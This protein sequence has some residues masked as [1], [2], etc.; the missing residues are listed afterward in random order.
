MIDLI[1]ATAIRYENAMLNSNNSK[2]IVEKNSSLA[3][4][5][6]NIETSVVHFFKR[7]SVHSFFGFALVFTEVQVYSA[8]VP[9]KKTATRDRL[10]GDFVSRFC[11]QSL[12]S[13]Q[14]QDNPVITQLVTASLKCYHTE[15]FTAFCGLVEELYFFEWS[16]TKHALDIQSQ[17]TA[18]G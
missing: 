14:G 15:S 17:F 13:R 4:M 7:F 9:A 6:F 5:V 12:C 1:E 3:L 16:G 8:S 2:L 10:Q 11:L 18:D